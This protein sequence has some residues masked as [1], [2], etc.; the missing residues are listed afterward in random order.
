[1]AKSPIAADRVFEH[2]ECFYQAFAGLCR[3]SPDPREDLHAATGCV[4]ALVL[5]CRFCRS[6]IFAHLG[7]QEA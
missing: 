7:W 6:W 5:Q 2:A 1:M 3:L 4:P